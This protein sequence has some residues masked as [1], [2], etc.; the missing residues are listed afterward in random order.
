MMG[1]YGSKGKFMTA[2]ALHSAPR[3][4]PLSLLLCGNSGDKSGAIHEVIAHIS[5]SIDTLTEELQELSTAS[6]KRMS[7]YGPFLGRS[8]LELASTALIARLDPFKL[9]VLREK[10]KQP[11][12]EVDKPHKASIRWQGDVLSE[13][14]K[15]KWEDKSLTSPTR[16]LLGDYYMELVW[17]KNFDL[18]IDSTERVTG[19]QWIS[20]LRLKNAERLYGE[21]RQG[22]SSHY[23]ALSKGI[24]HELVVPMEAVF[25]R[26]T[27]KELIKKVIF[28]VSTLGLITSLIN[29]SLNQ[30]PL[31]EAVTAYKEIQG[32]EIL[33]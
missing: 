3:Q 11:N 15:D 19:D 6:E 32:M 23:S 2:A 22:F 20:D 8:L 28:H 16:A 4:S 12:Y 18:L 31:N 9:L 33:K 26:E 10:Q 5:N 21:I 25:D 17:H 1:F 27:I 14:V 24:H 13:Q 29:H 7:F 30:L